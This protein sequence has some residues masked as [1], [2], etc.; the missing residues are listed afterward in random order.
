MRMAGGTL[1]ILQNP[2]PWEAPAHTQPDTHPEGPRPIRQPVWRGP[3]GSPGMQPPPS[4]EPPWKGPAP[5]IAAL[6]PPRC[7]LRPWLSPGPKAIWWGVPT[8]PHNP[9]HPALPWEHS[10]PGRPWDNCRGYPGPS[11][12]LRMQPLYPTPD[13]SWWASSLLQG[14]SKPHSAALLKR[15]PVCSLTELTI[16][17]PVA[18]SCRLPAQSCPGSAAH[19]LSLTQDRRCWGQAGLQAPDTGGWWPVGHG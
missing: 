12:S 16:S 19:P 18:C 11:G 17:P 10:R 8:G 7:R 5:D 4:Q 2:L 15:P 3:P 1:P 14:R 6:P 9:S 13:S